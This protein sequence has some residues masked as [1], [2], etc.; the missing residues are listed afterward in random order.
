MKR[1]PD[2]FYSY[3]LVANL[4]A[5]NTPVDNLGKVSALA[6]RRR[7]S[8]EYHSIDE[9][10][11]FREL[12]EPRKLKE[13]AEPETGSNEL[14][15][16]ENRPNEFRSNEF[17][18][19]ASSSN[20]P[21]TTSS[22]ASNSSSDLLG[23]LNQFSALSHSNSN[24]TATIS[25]QNGTST[26]NQPNLNA[27]TA[28][29][30]STVPSTTP[31]S[32]TASPVNSPPTTLPPLSSVS[33]DTIQ[34]NP[35]IPY[36]SHYSIKQKDL[37]K[38]IW[39]K[40]QELRESFASL[41][42]SL[43][44]KLVQESERYEDSVENY[45]LGAEKTDEK[46]E[47]ISICLKCHYTCRKCAGRKSNQCTACYQDSQLD[48]ESGRCLFKDLLNDMSKAKSTGDLWPNVQFDSRVQNWI[49]IF[50]LLL[51]LFFS[52][53]F[54]Y[55]LLCRRAECPHK[56]FPELQQYKNKH[57]LSI[58]EYYQQSKL[59]VEPLNGELHEP[60][61]EP[62]YEL[63]ATFDKPSFFISFLRFFKSNRSGCS[64][65]KSGS[66]CSQPGNAEVKYNSI[67]LGF[68]MVRGGQTVDTNETGHEEIT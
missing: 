57:S 51:C 28:N 65:P 40:Q 44:Q 54:F 6:N 13:F 58:A 67:P 23:Q 33:S 7:S 30:S 12:K 52:V 63:A 60:A 49:T 55:L 43:Y 17:R 35:Y 27:V 5:L 19:N 9:F 14:R 11:Q 46:L 21:Q 56:S 36:S 4:D 26:A 8:T 29:S 10:N 1:C 22:S 42:N 16:N 50:S 68:E 62:P 66:K 39:L 47:R 25:S 37:N 59:S 41:K 32:S 31:S 64:G 15:S 53:G 3:E 20:H 61:L 48:G 34:I 2:N 18:S 38:L 24:E 45:D